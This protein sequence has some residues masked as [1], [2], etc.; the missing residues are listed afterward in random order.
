MPPDRELPRCK[1]ARRRIANR[2]HRLIL[3]A[4]NDD[5]GGIFGTLLGSYT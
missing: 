3:G 5:F 4:H 1:S 2:P